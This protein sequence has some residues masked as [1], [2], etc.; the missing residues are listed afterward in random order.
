MAS[1]AVDVTRVSRVVGY[2]LNTANF[3]TVAPNLPQRIVVI[4]E[5][6]TDK[7]TGLDTSQIS[8]TSEYQAA[9]EYGYGSPLHQAARILRPQLGQ[10]LGGIPTIFI[11]QE[12][13]GGG[14]S[15]E[16]TV[17]VTGTA[18]ANATHSLVVC[19]R[20][21]LDGDNYSYSIE[22][23]DTENEIATKINDVIANVQASPVSGAVVTNVVTATT[24]YL[25]LVANDVNIT[26]NT[27]GVDAGIVYTIV[28]NGGGV[29]VPDITPALATF[30]EQWNTL[31]VSCYNLDCADV[32]SK[33]EAFNGV[34]DNTSP[35][36]QYTPIVQRPFRAI[37]GSVDDENTTFTDSKKDQVTIGLAPAPLSKGLPVEAAA[38]MVALYAPVSQNTPHLDISGKTY[39]DMPTPS[40]IGTMAVY[41]NR[42]AYVKLGNSTVTLASGKY[43]IQD[44]VTT[45]HPDGEPVPQHRYVRNFTV[46]SNVKYTYELKQRAIMQDMVIVADDDVVNVTGVIKPREWRSGVYDVFD[47][48]ALRALITD[49]EFSRESTVINLSTTNPNRLETFFRYKRTAVERISSTTAEAG[50]NFG[51]L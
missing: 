45:Y 49:V 6:N 26:V 17:T 20:E 14:G 10:G 33:L 37:F 25:S 4:G 38:N 35:T 2:Q 44:F 15:N 13:S 22:I 16:I 42:D 7:Q 9:Q 40:D 1:T 5:A 31:I 29:G 12:E 34:P 19:G 43:K 47:D 50:F 46:D 32:I 23:G 18:T 8:I 36:G 48:L 3:A 39:P 11:A 30:G 41:N 51:T 28:S 24:K 27:N 21:S